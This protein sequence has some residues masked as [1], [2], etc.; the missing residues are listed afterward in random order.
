MALQSRWKRPLSIL[1]WGLRTSTRSHRHLNTVSLFIFDTLSLS[2]YL[3]FVWLHLMHVSIHP[4]VMTSQKIGS[5]ILL[6]W[7]CLEHSSFTQGMSIYT[8]SLL[9]H[10]LFIQG[11]WHRV[12]QAVNDHFPTLRWV[13][14][15]LWWKSQAKVLWF[16]CSL[17]P[18]THLVV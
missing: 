6:M 7:R 16:V 5:S 2:F 3:L 1:S 17:P 12:P 4:Q 13:S 8:F 14:D 11:L 15:S 18:V 10:Q 9:K